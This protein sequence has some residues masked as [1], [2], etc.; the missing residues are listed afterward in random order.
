MSGC[1]PS[2]TKR[3]PDG[4]S[5]RS[6]RSASPA[7]IAPTMAEAAL[8]IPAVSHVGRLPGGGAFGLKQR[9]SEEHTSELQ[10]L[11]NLVCRL[12]LEKKKNQIPPGAS[13]SLFYTH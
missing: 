9:R 1:H 13:L 12:L 5:P 3:T 7:W 6:S 4:V 11:T 8:R 2:T 10:S